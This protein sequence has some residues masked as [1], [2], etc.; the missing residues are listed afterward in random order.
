MILVWIAVFAIGGFLRGSVAQVF[1]VV[2]LLVGL[3]AAIWVERWLSAHWQGAQP[4][5]VYTALR[6][7]VTILAG[8]AVVSLIQFWG[9]QIGRAVRTTPVGWLDHGG[10]V[11]VG[12]AVGLLTAALG[13]MLALMAP[14]SP[15]AAQ[16]VAR[17]RNGV[18]LMAGAAQACSLSVRFVPA[19]PWWV[20]RFQ[21]ARRCA[22]ATRHP[23]LPKKARRS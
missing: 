11:A 17:S 13:I 20:K 6:W 18:P 4:A 5:L 7:I 19:G 12:A 22:E 3:W 10:G 2:G 21:D 8:L 1:S 14:G 15:R 23:D 16:E 9:E